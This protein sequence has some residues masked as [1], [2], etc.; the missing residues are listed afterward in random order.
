M[1]FLLARLAWTVFPQLE[2]FLS[3][4]KRRK[5][6]RIGEN[7][8][9]SVEEIDG[10]KC[11]QIYAQS[12]ARSTSPRKRNIGQVNPAVSADRDGTYD[13]EPATEDDD[14][15][16]QQRGRKRLRSSRESFTYISTS[17]QLC[18]SSSEISASKN[19]SLLADM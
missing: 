13:D 15:E 1:E 7:G 4:G 18:R 8:A 12:R 5:V 11:Y 9:R 16:Y 2:I 14:D 17:G 19:A 3:S 10:E 6:S